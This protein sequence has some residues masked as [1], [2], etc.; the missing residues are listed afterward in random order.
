[1]IDVRFNPKEV[2]EK[3]AECEFV[4]SS[5]LHGLIVANGLEVPN[6]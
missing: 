4:Y 1:M 6:Q 5:S 3:I 2:I